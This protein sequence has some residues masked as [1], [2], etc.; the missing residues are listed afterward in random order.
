MKREYTV[1]DLI[2]GS[3]ELYLENERL[4]RFLKYS[5][6]ADDIK[7]FDFILRAMKDIKGFKAGEK[8]AVCILND[9][10]VAVGKI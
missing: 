2:F 3:R 4:M 9:H 7:N 5:C 10:S 6:N 8:Y 1:R